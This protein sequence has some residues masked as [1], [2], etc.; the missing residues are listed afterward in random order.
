MRPERIKVL[1]LTL[2][3]PQPRLPR[4]RLF[5]NEYI[6]RPLGAVYVGELRGEWLVGVPRAWGDRRVIIQVCEDK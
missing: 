2:C 5:V 4:N 3:H 6:G 1:R